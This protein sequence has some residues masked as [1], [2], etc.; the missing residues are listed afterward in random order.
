MAMV[1]IDLRPG[2]RVLRSFG[3]IA[4]AGF[5]LLGGVIYW[6]EGLFG[7]SFGEASG[8]V[9]CVLWCLAALAALLSL[10][11]PAANRPLYV[12]LVLV[13][14]PIGYVLSYVLM[15]AVFYGVIM[16]IGLVFRALRCDPLRRQFDRQT[17][18]YWVHHR[19]PDTV[20][21]YFRQF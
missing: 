20:E 1:Q 5:G 8:T 16:P 10:I 19:A 6:K 3:F 14:Y 2:P 17:P 9:S 7:L 12:A 4:L 21:R 13:T 15:G 18:T 11:A